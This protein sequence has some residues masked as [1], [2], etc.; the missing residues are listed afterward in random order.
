MINYI[1]GKIISKIE[2]YAIIENNGI[3]YEINV[4]NT[5]LVQLPTIGEIAHIHTV[6]LVKD[7]G[8]SL[9]G[10]STL[11]E[12]E[13]FNKLTTVSGVGAKSA[14]AIL[15]SQPYSSLIA[16]I[17]NGDATMLSKAKGIGKK[18]AERIVL[19]LKDKVSA[20]DALNMRVNNLDESSI[21]ARQDVADA[22]DLLVSLGI[23]SGQATM[24][25]KRFAD[26]CKTAEELV[27]RTLQN[28]NS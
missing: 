17:I 6:M 16:C 13:L 22:I 14:L 21:L 15:S 9:F 8:I 19:E 3:G 20:T 26:E 10:F 7:D 23:P 27:S 2:G 18:T 25:V 1:E 5:T 28:L 12:K 11:E 24:L 4:S